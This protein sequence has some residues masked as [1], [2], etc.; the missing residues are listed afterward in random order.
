MKNPHQITFKCPKC[1]RPYLGTT[2]VACRC[3]VPCESGWGTSYYSAE[4]RARVRAWMQLWRNQSEDK[5][6]K[7]VEN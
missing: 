6:G 1:G 4:H 5:N 2:D 3:F 7:D